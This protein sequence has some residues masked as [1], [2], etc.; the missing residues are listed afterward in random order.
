VKCAKPIASCIS[1]DFWADSSIATIVGIEIDEPL[2]TLAVQRTWKWSR[3]HG[4]TQWTIASKPFTEALKLA[5]VRSVSHTYAL[6]K[7][8]GLSDPAK[9]RTGRGLFDFVLGAYTVKD[10]LEVTGPGM[11]TDAVMDAMYANDGMGALGDTKAGEGL[12]WR[13]FT[14]L[15]S[16]EVVGDILVL[17][18][19]Y[20]ASGQR[21]SGAGL[22]DVSEACVNHLARRTWKMSQLS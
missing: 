16:P 1:P 5:I 18:V 11:W 15:K 9:L 20:L 14:G 2:A 3:N 21:H 12:S 10:I 4:F 13:A 6:A 22:F 8:R 19:N 7:K 17:P